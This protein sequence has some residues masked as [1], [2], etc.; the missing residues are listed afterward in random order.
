MKIYPASQAIPVS[1]VV[2]LLL[3]L[4]MPGTAL[5]DP[6]PEWAL[7]DVN[8]KAVK[9]SDFPGKVVV[10]D[11]WATWCPPCRA[12]IPHFVSLQDKYKKQGL[13]I[14]QGTASLSGQPLKADDLWTL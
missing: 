12:E 2:L 11:F 13:V 10:I 14:K 9:L 3:A 6:A 1:A 5:A 4:I 7:T 8:G